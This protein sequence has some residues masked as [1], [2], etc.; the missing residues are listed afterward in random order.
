MNKIAI[1]DIISIVITFFTLVIFFA[2]KK[3]KFTLDIKLSVFCILFLNMVY[4]ISLFIEW[5]KETI[6]LE[7]FEN[8]TGGLIPMF[9]AFLFYTIIQKK[10]LYD[11]RSGEERLDMALKG[12]RAGLWDW[13]VQTG[14]LIVNDRWAEIIGYTQE[15]LKPVDINTWNKFTHPDDL[16]ISSNILKKHFQG[17]SDFYECEIRM[18]HKNGNWIWVMDRGMVIERDEKYSAVRMIG[19]HIEITQQKS[20]EI[21]LKEEIEKNREI[22]KKYEVKNKELTESLDK[23][24]IINQQLVEA[25]EKAEE[26]EKLKTAFLANLS[27]EIRT[28]MNGILGFTDLLKNSIISGKNIERYINAI[29]NS[30]NRM[31][32]I[33]N[34]IIDLSRIESGYIL[35]NMEKIDINSVLCDLYA[36]FKPETENKGIELVIDL[37]IKNNQLIIETDKTKFTQII[38]NL[39]KNAIK[40][41]DKG[42]VGFGYYIENDIIYFYVK[43][44]GIGIPQNQHEKIFERFR[45]A[46][47]SS[48]R[49]VEGAG[50]G[51]SISR[52]YA[53]MLGGKISLKSEINTGSE[54]TFELPYKNIY[55]N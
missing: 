9:W 49:T 14:K 40:Y 50:L 55:N 11:L 36:F 53:G 52:A 44:T 34:D 21:K 22:N 54:F 29:Q 8:L 5:D 26:S 24:K 4:F 42:S 27:H 17:I 18:K 19:T 45:Q 16:I 51:L 6:K 7:P 2:F 3:H 48:I 38:S 1:I 31:L 35:I 33:L 32:N 25:K 41:T 37:G 30:G 46:D 12:T 43:D 23:I 28:P 20:N 10:T 39:L 15:E 47:D 13:Q